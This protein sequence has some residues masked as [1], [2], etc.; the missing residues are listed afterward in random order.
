MLVYRFLSSQAR[1]SLFLTAYGGEL[2]PRQLFLYSFPAATYGALPYAM[3]GFQ[4]PQR[5]TD[6]AYPQTP[7]PACVQQRCCL[8][9]NAYA[10][11]CQPLLLSEENLCLG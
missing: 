2:S 7:R 8:R 11:R 9:F 1:L 3:I 6:R 4:R 10:G 5:S